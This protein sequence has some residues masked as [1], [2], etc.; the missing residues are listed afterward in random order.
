MTTLRNDNPTGGLS[1]SVVQYTIEFNFRVPSSASRPQYTK[2]PWQVDLYLADHSISRSVRYEHKPWHP[3]GG[4]HRSEKAPYR[5]VIWPTWPNTVAE[6]LHTSSSPLRDL[7]EHWDEST[8]RLRESAKWMATVI[9]AALASVIPV[10]PLTGLSKHHLSIAQGALGAFGLFCLG[11]TLLLVLQVMRPQPVA[12]DDVQDAEAP[13]TEEQ[14]LWRRIPLRLRRSYDLG[15]AL[16][17]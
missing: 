11:L 13:P 14:R 6:E 5:E 10:A 17:R 9:G 1:R 16:Y 4:F 3:E 2:G 15:S 12:F 7:Q 8:S